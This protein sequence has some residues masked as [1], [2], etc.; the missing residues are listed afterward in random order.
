MLINNQISM[1]TS[2]IA[3]KISFTKVQKTSVK[4]SPQ[5]QAHENISSKEL[6]SEGSCPIY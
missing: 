3:Y 1:L 2:S 4:N 6:S 5:L